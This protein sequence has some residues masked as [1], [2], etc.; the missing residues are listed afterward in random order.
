VS[1]TIGVSASA[2][3][4]SVTGGASPG[5]GCAGAGSGGASEMFTTTVRWAVGWAA[6][7]VFVAVGAGV[8]VRVGLG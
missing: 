8:A 2:D 7:G 6:A 3:P 5:S 1:A 4:E